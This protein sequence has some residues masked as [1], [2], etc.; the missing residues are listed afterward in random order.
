[1][2]DGLGIA[3]KQDMQRDTEKKEINRKL[4]TTLFYVES[5][6]PPLNA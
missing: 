4:E 3:L 2:G 5:I 6:F 1:M